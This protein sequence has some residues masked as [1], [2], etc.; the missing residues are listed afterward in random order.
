MCRLG[1]G[2]VHDFAQVKKRALCRVRLRAFAG[3][4]SELA[5]GKEIELRQHAIDRYEKDAVQ[6]GYLPANGKG[7]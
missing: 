1:L 3:T 7:E 2:L 4:M 5:F 6:K